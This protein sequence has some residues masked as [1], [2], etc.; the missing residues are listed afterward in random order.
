[1]GAVQSFLI[2]SDGTL[3]GPI[4]TVGSGGNGPAYCVQFSNGDVA[5]MNYGSGSGSF[6]RTVN[7]GKFEPN[8]TSVNF[9]PTNASHPHMA[10][11]YGGKVFV[12]DLVSVILYLPFTIRA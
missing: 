9:P 2:N 6:T 12:P 3:S 7:E 5:T 4:D 1:M 10:L 11:E 8:P